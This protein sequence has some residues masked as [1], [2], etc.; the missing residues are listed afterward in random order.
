MIIYMKHPVHGTKVATLELEAQADE[1]N[2]W[3]RY[4]INES[5][6]VNSDAVVEHVNFLQSKR[7]GRPPKVSQ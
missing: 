1:E 5:S 3:V 4:T 2:G 7:R 6:E